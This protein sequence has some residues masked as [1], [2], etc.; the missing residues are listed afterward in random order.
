MWCVKKFCF[1]VKTFGFVFAIPKAFAFVL[2]PMSRTVVTSDSAP[3]AIGPYSQVLLC[4]QFV[5]LS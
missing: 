2:A 1:G 3:P 5:F 4:F